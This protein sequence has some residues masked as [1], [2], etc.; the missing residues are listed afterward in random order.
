MLW[1]PFRINAFSDRATKL[2]Q[3]CLSE[4]FQVKELLGCL[5]QEQDLG[6]ANEPSKMICL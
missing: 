3:N 4:S 2:G 1:E 5:T 6:I